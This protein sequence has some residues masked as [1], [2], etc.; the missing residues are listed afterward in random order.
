MDCLKIKNL[1]PGYLNRELP[2]KE[3]ERIRTHLVDCARCRQECLAYEKSWD[4]L[5]QWEDLE[6]KP[7][8]VSRFWT[9]LALRQPW[10]VRV[11]SYVKEILLIRRFVPVY[12]TAMVVFIVGI[13]TLRTSFII[14]RDSRNF[15]TFPSEDIEFIESLDL[16]VNLDVLNDLDFLENMR[17]IEKLPKAPGKA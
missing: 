10:Y 15:A 11:G 8:Y 9:Q 2:T 12:A 1:I 16:T 14:Y 4:I 7:G 5:Q 3:A 13:F 17:V 6:P